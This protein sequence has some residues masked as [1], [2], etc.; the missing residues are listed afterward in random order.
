MT[1]VDMHGDILSP[2]L[3][4]LCEMTR[5]AFYLFFLVSI[6]PQVNTA[7]EPAATLPFLEEKKNIAKN[8]I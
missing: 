8:F 4:A 1:G 6:C 2:F 3:S 5:F 7:T